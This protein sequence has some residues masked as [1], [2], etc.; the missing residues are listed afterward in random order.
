MKTIKINDV[1][2]KT[3]NKWIEIKYLYSTGEAYFMN[4]GKKFYLNNVMRIS[5][6][7]YNDNNIHGICSLQWYKPDFIS[8]NSTGEAVKIYRQV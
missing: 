2:L 4:N 1:E 7:I 5:D 6:K 8:I 3:S